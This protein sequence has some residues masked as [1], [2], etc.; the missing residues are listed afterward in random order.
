MTTEQAPDKKVKRCPNWGYA[1]DLKAKLCKRCNYPFED[2]TT[3]P[4][5][6]TE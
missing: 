1:N 2:D 3:P 4:P 6:P 5:A